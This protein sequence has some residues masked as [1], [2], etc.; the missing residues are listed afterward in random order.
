MRCF[1]ISE[2]LEQA[3]YMAGDRNAL[4][5]KTVK[6]KAP[7]YIQVSELLEQA[8]TWQEIK[9][10]LYQKIVK[11]KEPQYTCDAF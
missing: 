6:N 9:R 1:P 5:Q 2:H 11:N 7:Q 10:A 3:Q 8:H 4:C